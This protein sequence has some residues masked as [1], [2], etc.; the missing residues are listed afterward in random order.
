MF[1]KLEEKMLELSS[2]KI[3][4]RSAIVKLSKGIFSLFGIA[5][6]SGLPISRV[7]AD[8]SVPAS[9]ELEAVNCN[10]C[11]YCGIG[12][13]PCESCGGGYGCQGSGNK[14]GDAWYA[15]CCSDYAVYKYQDCCG[16]TAL[17]CDTWCPN[18]TEPSW[19]SGTGAYRCTV[20]T[21]TP[22]LC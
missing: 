21:K 12:G 3:S 8:S 18:A 11:Q 22:M 7:R 13:Y 14:L 10:S 20:V 15:C 1:D 16:T 4:R 6:L 5:F 19:C 17:N 2:E 9:N